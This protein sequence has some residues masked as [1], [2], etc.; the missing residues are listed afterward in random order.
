[1]IVLDTNIAIAYLGGEEKI[2]ERLRA[3]IAA[4]EEIFV[5]TIVAAELL[6]YPDLDAQVVAQTKEWLASI[7]VISLDLP[8][9]ERAA[10][11]RR[12]TKLKLTDSA[13]AAT[14]L[15]YHAALATRDQGF[16]K[17]KGLKILEW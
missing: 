5:P 6:A 17:V 7:T 15:F 8:L 10:E 13:V 12:S 1:M 9:A 4:G 3:A 14:A 11:T 2:G 16:R